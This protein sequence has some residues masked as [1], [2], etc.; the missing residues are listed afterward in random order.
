MVWA[1]HCGR[2]VGVSGLYLG[3]PGFKSRHRN[4]L[5]LLRF[6]VAFLIPSR[7]NP[8]QVLLV[9]FHILNYHPRPYSHLIPYNIRMNRVENERL[10]SSRVTFI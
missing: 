5:A 7:Q 4:R 6:F 8:G 2:V 10:R 3:G 9:S 1:E